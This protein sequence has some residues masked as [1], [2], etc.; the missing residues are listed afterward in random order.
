MRI[1]EGFEF[2]RG[3]TIIHKLDP[4]VKMFYSISIF[5]LSM[6]FWNSI[7][8]LLLF[9][10]ILPLFYI[11]KVSQK[12]IRT[13]QGSIFLIILIFVINYFTLG[14]ERALAMSFRFLT[15]I[16]CFSI[17][18]LTTYPEDFSEAL[19]KL[20]VPYEF[21]LTFTMAIRFV[22][23]L[24]REARIIIDAQRSR[25][26][27]LDKGNFIKKL[28]NYIP[29]LVPLIVNAIRK[30]IKVAE[31]M[32][33]R[34]FGASPKRTSLIELRLTL[35]DYLFLIIN[36]IVTLLLIYAKYYLNIES[37]FPLLIFFS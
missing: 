20:K 7:I 26:L 12:F 2:K 32:E 18:F 33:S 31:A 11:A 21:A 34:A 16:A 29:I 3:N 1:L 27:E 37:Y 9:V 17:L 10:S 30:S 4:R 15:I 36:L 22:P 6:I 13:L 35:K 19:V 28:K 25:G 14:I 8:L 5:I 24:A 23:S